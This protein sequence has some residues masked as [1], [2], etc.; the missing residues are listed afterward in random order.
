MHRLKIAYQTLSHILI[1]KND[2]LDLRTCQESAQAK[3][4]A[5][6]LVGLGRFHSSW[7]VADRIC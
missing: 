1:I 5:D 4:R 6:F 7:V 2:L 3:A